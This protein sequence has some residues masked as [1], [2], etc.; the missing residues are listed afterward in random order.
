MPRRF[1]CVIRPCGIAAA[2]FAAQICHRHI[3]GS[4]L[5]LSGFESL[6]IKKNTTRLGGVF[7]GGEGGIRTLETLLTFT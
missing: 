5:T 4:P 2:D 6:P 3:F 1:A 7:F